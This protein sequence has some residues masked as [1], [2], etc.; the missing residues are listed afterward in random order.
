MTPK[1]DADMTVRDMMARDPVTLERNDTL[2]LAEDIMNL[3]RIRHMPV[4]D[5]PNKRLLRKQAS[6]IILGYVPDKK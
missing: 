6:A 1:K 5:E 3:G 4:E 2:D